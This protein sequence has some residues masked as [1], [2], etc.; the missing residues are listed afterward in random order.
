MGTEAGSANR[1][2]AA[3]LTDWRR[4]KGLHSPEQAEREANWAHLFATYRDALAVAAREFLRRGL[5]RRPD[6]ADVAGVVE[7][8]LGEC[9][10]QRSLEKADPSKGRF[11]CYLWTLLHDFA[12]AELTRRNAKR[13][14]PP[15]GSKRVPVEE[16]VA[17]GAEPARPAPE[18]DEDYKR[19]WFAGAIVEALRALRDR[20]PRYADEM[21]RL[22]ASSGV[23]DPSPAAHLR[24]PDARKARSDARKAFATELRASLRRT[25]R[26]PSQV[27]AEWTELLRWLPWLAKVPAQRPLRRA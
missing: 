10:S 23:L 26:L 9:W 17:R 11:R 13:R 1:N 2:L 12:C 14:N 27:R 16:V 19:S 4:V 15:R 20:H 25:V 6:D 21:E 3:I 5:G 7:D 8:F 18:M 24:R 22:V